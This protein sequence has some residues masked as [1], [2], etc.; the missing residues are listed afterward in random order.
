MGV[1]SHMFILKLFAQVVSEKIK[2]AQQ[3]VTI[4]VTNNCNNIIQYALLERFSTEKSQIVASL[5]KAAANWV[6]A[7]RLASSI[8][9]RSPTESNKELF[10]LG[11][12][13]WNMIVCVKTHVDGNFFVENRI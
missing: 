6:A 11:M 10:R 13:W 1:G 8:I 9:C 7:K 3:S 4:S 12:S 2:I 5:L